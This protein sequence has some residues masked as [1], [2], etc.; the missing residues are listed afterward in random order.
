MTKKEILK[1]WQGMPEFKQ[2]KKKEIKVTAKIA[3]RA[4][5]VRFRNF[6]DLD[7]LS[8]RCNLFDGKVMHFDSVESFALCAE[9]RITA[10]TK[11]I[12]FP[13]KSHWGGITK[14]WISTEPTKNRYPVYIVSKGRHKNGLTTKALDRMGVSHFIVVE[15]SQ[16]QMYEEAANKSARIITLPQSYLDEYETMDDLRNAK[17]KG[18]GA[19]RNFC[20]DHSTELGFSRHWVMDDNLDAFHRMNENEKYEVECPSTLAAAEDF[21][22]RF[23]NA[24]VAGLNYYSFCKKKRCC[25]AICAQH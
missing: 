16:K 21:V 6:D 1:L 14:K 24:P 3:E 25:A 20:I 7:T 11:S 22:D 10:K 9:Q 18:P 17:S 2:E 15:E 4:I 5:F 23:S 13:F 19:A 12:W 8:K